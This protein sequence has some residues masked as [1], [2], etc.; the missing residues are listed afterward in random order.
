MLYEFIK[1]P[2]FCAFVHGFQRNDSN[3][4]NS[5]CPVFQFVQKL[6]N[7]IFWSGRWISRLDRGSSLTL[8]S[9]AVTIRS[10]IFFPNLFSYTALKGFFRFFG[11]EIFVFNDFKIYNTD[12][13]HK[14]NPSRLHLFVY[15]PRLFRAM[16]IVPKPL[17]TASLHPLVYTPPTFTG[18]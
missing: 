1:Q 5:G 17:L 10:S 18:L 3:S 12:H 13:N 16:F 4:F 9:F 6:R 8:H 7:P 14:P 15:N 2:L 11:S